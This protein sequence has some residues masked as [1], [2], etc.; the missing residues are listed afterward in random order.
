MTIAQF[1]DQHESRI[2]A[3]MVMGPVLIG[4][5]PLTGF[6]NPL[7]GSVFGFPLYAVAQGHPV[8]GPHPSSELA[9]FFLW[10]IVVIASMIWASGAVLRTNSRWRPAVIFL[11]CLSA[12]AVVPVYRAFDQFSGWPIYCACE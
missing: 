10:P 8:Y 5:Y 11:W 9:A 3:F 6:I 7:W 2:R 1:I 4:A 12:F